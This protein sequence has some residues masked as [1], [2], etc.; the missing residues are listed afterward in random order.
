MIPKKYRNVMS[1]WSSTTPPKAAPK[2]R[3]GMSPYNFT[4]QGQFEK[5][6][7]AATLLYKAN[8]DLD[9]DERTG[10]RK[11]GGGFL[12]AMQYL[13]SGADQAGA[14]PAPVP[15]GGP[16]NPGSGG[17]GRGRGYGGGGGGGGGI[18]PAVAAQAQM[19]YLS[20]LL[21]GKNYTAAPLQGMRDANQAL[22]NTVATATAQDQAAATGAYNSLD[23]WLAQ[24]QRNPY[25]D[26]QLQ[27]AQA[28]PDMNPYLASQGVPGTNYQAS[29][30]EDTG[31]GA[32]QNVLA[33]LGANQLAGQQSRAAES[34][35]ARTYAGQQ[36]GAMDNAYLANIAGRDAE[37]AKLEA[38]RQTALDTERRQAAMQLAQLIAQGAKA[39][40]L[41][42]LGLA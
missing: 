41:A 18:D 34:Q 39:P 30:P 28:A 15:P 5:N 24:N 21:A 1:R 27:R 36:I 14:G 17:S 22:R 37:V 40:D 35:M 13:N 3:P 16:G 33:L 38:D 19:D 25:A 29:N 26:V 7:R 12:A 31:Y 6:S 9:I 20:Q 2:S 11:A 42:A 10:E 8:P 23:S 32:F 4:G